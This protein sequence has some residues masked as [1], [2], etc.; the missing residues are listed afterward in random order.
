MTTDNLLELVELSTDRMLLGLTDMSDAQL[1]EP[2]LLPGWTRGHVLTHLARNADALVNLLSWARTG[3]RKD[4]YPSR[5]ARNADIESG[6]G[7]SVAELRDDLTQSHSRFREYAGRLDADAWARRVEWGADMR[8]GAAEFVLVLRA[9]EVELHRTDLGLGH[10]PA[11]WP[12]QML[13]R[14]L[15]Y[16]ASDLAERAGEALTLQATDTWATLPFGEPGHVEENRTIEGPQAALAA[17][18]TGRSDGRDLAVVPAGELPQ[19]GDWR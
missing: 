18:V 11:E 12:A 9:V 10:P 7:R 5:E 19:I 4:M 14:F 16:A 17:W 8:G 3:E 13:T 1:R 15:P 2:S 6:A